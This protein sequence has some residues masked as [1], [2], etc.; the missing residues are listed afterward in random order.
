MA[1]AGVL[2]KP[3]PAVG[4][5]MQADAVG[6]PKHAGLYQRAARHEALL[7]L[8]FIWEL[9]EIMAQANG[10]RWWTPRLCTTT[11]WCVLGP[12]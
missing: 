7:S 1:S 10:W 4:G 2:E 12:R 5:G 8:F 3:G 6:M 9:N 11:S